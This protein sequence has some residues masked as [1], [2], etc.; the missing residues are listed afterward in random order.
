MPDHTD[1]PSHQSHQTNQ[2]NPSSRNSD[3]NNNPTP[4]LLESLQEQIRRSQEFG[5]D[6][7]VED[8]L[9][10]ARASRTQ[11]EVARQ[12]IANEILEATKA[13]CQKLIQDGE[14]TLDRA[15]RMEAQSTKN[16]NQAQKEL[17]RAQA[18]RAQADAYAEK[19]RSEAETYS[20]KLRN[21]AETYAEKLRNETQQQSQAKLD[22]AQTI[23][24]AADS[25]REQ[26]LT[27]T[28][29]QG[30]EILYQARATAQQESGDIRQQAS[31]EAQRMRADAELIKAAAREE[32][33]AQKIYAEA[34]R[35][36][37][38]SREVLAQVRAKL[39]GRTFQVASSPVQ[40]DYATAMESTGQWAQPQPVAETFDTVQE[41]STAPE[42]Q[43]ETKTPR[44]GRSS[45]SRKQ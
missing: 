24:T 1:K 16:Q 21:E 13:V 17:E 30:Q 10:Q 20:Q 45:A 14:E 39:G 19:L 40:Q 25:Y 4:S 33:E 42:T 35:L 2:A 12:Q 15:K 43:S 36:E 29:Q 7:S 6:A 37:A 34:A 18:V 26:V 38:E 11:A 9:A 22:E 28:E 32:M 5:S 23:R 31:H 41:T 27:E 3:R 44:S 8:Q